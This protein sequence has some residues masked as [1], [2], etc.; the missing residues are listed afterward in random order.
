MDWVEHAKQKPED[1]QYLWYFFEIT[2]VA[3]GRY[4]AEGNCYYGHNG[5]LCGDVTHWMPAPNPPE[6]D[7]AKITHRE[8][9]MTKRS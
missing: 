6:T 9:V 3:Y 2:G 8:E 7:P 5:F 4:D 1:G